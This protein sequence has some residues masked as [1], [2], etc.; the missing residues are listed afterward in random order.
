MMDRETVRNMWNFIPKI[1]LRKLVHLFGFVVR[2]GDAL[3]PERNN[4]S[5]V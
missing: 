2:I 4:S 3:S 5:F 1:N